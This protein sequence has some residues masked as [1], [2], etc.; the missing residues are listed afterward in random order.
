MFSII[1]KV[2]HEYGQP[3]L[4]WLSGFVSAYFQIMIHK[5]EGKLLKL[6]IMCNNYSEKR[7]MRKDEPISQHGGWW[8]QPNI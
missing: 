5:V 8:S 2:G 3:L 7:E 4:W 6:S 1:I